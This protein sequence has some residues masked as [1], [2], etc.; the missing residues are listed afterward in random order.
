VRHKRWWLLV[1]MGILVVSFGAST[2]ESA[3]AATVAPASIRGTY[4]G[5]TKQTA[6]IG[7]IVYLAKITKHTLVRGSSESNLYRAKILRVTR[8]G[9]RYA[10][11]IR[12][13]LGKH[14]TYSMVHLTRSTHRKVKISGISSSMHRVTQRHYQQMMTKLHLRV[15]N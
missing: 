15:I 1:L 7:S 3:Q 4:R 9:N 2:A 14:A 5:G 11:K 13:K 8:H 6:G 10:L 12:Q